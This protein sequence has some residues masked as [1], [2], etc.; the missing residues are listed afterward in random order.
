MRR[1]SASGRLV[2]SLLISFLL[3][4]TALA[5]AGRST[6]QGTLKDPQGNVIAG[7]TVTITNAGKNFNRT[8]TTNQGGSYIFIAVPPV[9]YRL[10]IVDM[11]FEIY[12]FEHVETPPD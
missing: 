10:K 12:V 9:T 7:A 1:T 3:F 2:G 11:G 6:V 8:H 4:I 5:Q